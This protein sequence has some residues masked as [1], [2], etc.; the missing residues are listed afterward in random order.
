MAGQQGRAR[1]LTVGPT[2]PRMIGSSAPT[3][4]KPLAFSPHRAQNRRGRNEEYG[5]LVRGF[6]GIGLGV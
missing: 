6:A 3:G 4:A 2:E 5:S 1:S